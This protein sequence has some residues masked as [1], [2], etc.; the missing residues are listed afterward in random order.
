MR[1]ASIASVLGEVLEWQASV[2]VSVQRLATGDED[3][4]G[5]EDTGAEVEIMLVPMS[6]EEIE[7]RTLQ[8]EH[9]T[10]HK[11]FT[12]A[13]SGIELASQLTVVAR[14]DERGRWTALP[15]DSGERYLVRGLLVTPG[16]PEPW[17]NRAAPIAADTDEGAH[18]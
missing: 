16:V 4:P 13:S 15:A 10:T 3:S 14:R 11:A 8:Y 12:L 2:R 7:T 5:W 18:W 9:P 1:Q 6:T 17:I